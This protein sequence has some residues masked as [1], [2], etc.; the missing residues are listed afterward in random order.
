MSAAWYCPAEEALSGEMKDRDVWVIRDL[1]EIPELIRK[2]TSADGRSG[3]E[4]DI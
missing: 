4:E 2:K 3:R 1:S